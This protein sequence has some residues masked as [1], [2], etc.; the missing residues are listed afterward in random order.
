MQSNPLNV[1]KASK[2]RKCL[3]ML[4]FMH[5]HYEP[6]LIVFLGFSLVAKSFCAFTMCLDLLC[7]LELNVGQQRNKKQMKLHFA[8][9]RMLMWMCEAERQDVL[10]G[11]SLDEK[12]TLVW[13]IEGLN[14]LSGKVELTWSVELLR[15]GFK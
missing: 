7:W 11:M 6:R 15:H 4:H 5:L 1:Q 9:M 8:G 2:Y 14:R 12:T 10:R 3:T 13:W